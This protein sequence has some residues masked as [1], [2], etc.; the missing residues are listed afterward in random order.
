M[1][2]ELQL[3]ERIFKKKNEIKT[4]FKNCSKK[5]AKSSKNNKFFYNTNL[6]LDD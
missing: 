1:T 4:T 2:D 5:F 3:I 6:P